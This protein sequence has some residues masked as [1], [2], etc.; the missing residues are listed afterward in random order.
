[1]VCVRVVPVDRSAEASV[2]GLSRCWSVSRCPVLGYDH[3]LHIGR[4]G[5]REE[6]LFVGW[7]LKRPSNM[8]VYPRDGSA[9]TV[10]RAATLR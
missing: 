7:L 4:R 2:F 9:Q 3:H 8:R 5:D 1:M 10:V 6:G